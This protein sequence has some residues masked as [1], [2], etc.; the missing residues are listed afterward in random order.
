MD[1]PK[2]H[3]IFESDDNIISD[4]TLSLSQRFDAISIRLDDIDIDYLYNEVKEKDNSIAEDWKVKGN[5]FFK[6]KN[7]NEAARCYSEV[8]DH[9]CRLKRNIGLIL[10]RS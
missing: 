8:I 7:W 6:K 2:W 9:F 5:E 1:W 3:Q 4:G 10:R